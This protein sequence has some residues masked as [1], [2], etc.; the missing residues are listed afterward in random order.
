MKYNRLT[1]MGIAMSV[2]VSAFTVGYSADE[3]KLTRAQYQGNFPI[4]YSKEW[5]RA[6]F[7]SYADSSLP[8][9]R[10]DIDPLSFDHGYRGMGSTLYH[11]SMDP[12]NA[13]FPGA[14][15]GALGANGWVSL[16]LTENLGNSLERYDAPSGYDAS[17]YGALKIDRGDVILTIPAN[18]D[19]GLFLDLEHASLLRLSILSKKLTEGQVIKV[20]S[21]A[22]SG[23]H[24]PTIY[25][26][27]KNTVLPE[28]YNYKPPASGLSS[29]R[30]VFRPY[31]NAYVEGVPSTDRQYCWSSFWTG[32][33]ASNL[34]VSF[35]NDS[36]E[37]MTL[38]LRFFGRYPL[39][40]KRNTRGQVFVNDQ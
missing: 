9:Y 6:E 28:V 27:N 23:M 2:L 10:K 30:T 19:E 24:L 12:V 16:W 29:T 4:P 3:I 39:K 15:K 11:I 38:R 21:N 14:P 34:K 25:C 8:L 20:S 13:V 35:Q 31:K 1:I 18:S 7:R 17:R 36:D 22:G 26:R 33:D 37:E 32:S 5:K 40:L